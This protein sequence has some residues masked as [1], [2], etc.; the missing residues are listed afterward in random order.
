M[1]DP[2]GENRTFPILSFFRPCCRRCLGLSVVVG[3]PPSTHTP[4]GNAALWDLDP[5][6]CTH[7]PGPISWFR[8][9]LPSGQRAKPPGDPARCTLRGGTYDIGSVCPECRYVCTVCPFRPCSNV[10]YMHTYLIVQCLQYGSGSNVPHL[11]AHMTLVGVLCCE[12]IFTTYEGSR[13][14]PLLI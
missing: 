14:G 6:S 13:G 1:E 10:L 3:R 4:G 7:F 8:D 9:F 12:V 5:F 2:K 11:S